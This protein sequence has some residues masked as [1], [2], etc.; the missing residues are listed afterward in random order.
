MVRDETIILTA[1]QGYYIQ[2]NNGYIAINFETDEY[3][4]ATLGLI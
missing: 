2:L 3:A 4:P 1:T